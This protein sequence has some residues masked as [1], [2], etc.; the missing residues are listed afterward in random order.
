MAKKKKKYVKKNYNDYIIGID[1]S[2]N[3]TG[4]SV[5]SLS[6]NKIV[7]TGHIN[8]ETVRPL[9]KYRGYNRNAIKLNIQR[10][11]LE[12]IRRKFPP[13]VV[14]FE[15]G[16]AK[17]RKEVASLNQING[18]IYAIFWNYTQY[19]Y[20]P[21]TVKAE[22]VHGRAKKEIVRDVLLDNIPDLKGNEEFYNNDN[23]SDAVGVLYTYLLKEKI[24]PKSKWDKGQFPKSIPKKKKIVKKKG[25]IK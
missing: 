22:I 19:F 14:V 20:P 8:T 2:L 11:Y 9:K 7:F 13:R 1:I 23:V 17:F 10:E 21:T 6:E 18:V 3:D 12:D 15:K 16:F 4:V 5:Y 25:K 24:I